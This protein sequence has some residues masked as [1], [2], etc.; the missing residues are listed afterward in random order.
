MEEGFA[1]IGVQRFEGVQ[2]GGQGVEESLECWVL[3][4]VGVRAKVVA[5]LVDNAGR[6]GVGMHRSQISI[7]DFGEAA[8]A[9]RAGHPIIVAV[10]LK[11][12]CLRP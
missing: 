4:R 6:V 10:L 12:S 1:S 2:A 8:G 3:P 7:G 9:V 5:H 11:V